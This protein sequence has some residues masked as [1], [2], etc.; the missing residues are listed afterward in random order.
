M[1]LRPQSEIQTQRIKVKID[2]EILSY[3]PNIS[4][5]VPKH[6]HSKIISQREGEREETDSAMICQN[7]D[8]LLEISGFAR[9]DGKDFSSR[10]S[11]T[12]KTVQMRTCRGTKNS[13]SAF[14][15]SIG[16]S[17]VAVQ[18]AFAWGK[19]SRACVEQSW[20]IGRLAG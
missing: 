18:E 1:S 17:F 2:S 4:V 10:G 14:G 20:E 8:G 7:G 5:V 12:E 16:S 13:P 19:D 3:D 6:M 15:K 11:L 9:K